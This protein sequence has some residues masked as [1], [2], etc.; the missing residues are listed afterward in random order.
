MSNM[1][2]L[3]SFQSISIRLGDFATVSD[4]KIIQNDIKFLA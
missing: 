2:T 3:E 1:V 4:I